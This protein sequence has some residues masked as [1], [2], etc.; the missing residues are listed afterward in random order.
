[1]HVDTVEAGLGPAVL[2][3]RVL[4]EGERREGEFLVV[5]ID[6]LQP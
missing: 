5:A 6:S 1:V 2:P 3:V 4:D